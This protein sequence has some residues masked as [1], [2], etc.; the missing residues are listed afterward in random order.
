MSFLRAARAALAGQSFIRRI[1]TATVI[2]LVTLLVLLS[3]SCGG[4]TN[5]VAPN[6]NAFVTLPS[7]GSVLLLHMNGG[8]GSITLGSKT[9]PTVGFTPTGMALLPSRKFLYV[10][11]SQGYS[12]SVFSVASDYSLSLTAVPTPAG[13]GANQAVIDPTGQYLL[14]TNN[15]SNNI[16]V[17]SINS[18]TGALTEVQGSPFFANANP[19]AIVFAGNFV[20]VV[21]PGIGMVTG[22]SFNSGNGTLT[23]VPGSP[24]YSGKGAAALAVSNGGQ[25]LYVA[26]PSANNPPPYTA[27]IGNISGFNI[28]QTTGALTSITGSPFTAPVGTGPSAITIF[29]GIVYATTPGSSYSVWCFS[30][31]GQNGQL[32][33][34]ANSPFSVAGGGLFAVIDPSGKFFYIGNQAGSNIAGYTFNSSTGALSVVDNSPFA[35]GSAPG[36]M[37]FI[38]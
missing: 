34:V 10:I 16:S 35:I 38:Q 6:H 26:N 1:L 5:L 20:Y 32:V 22:F 2:V 19:T 14:V 13:S 33:P 15:F 30:I 28:D 23:Q 11:N 3:L 7:N 17:F 25:F 37:V 21:N 27:T 31:T 9:S 4:N 29:D 36:N 8:T 24:I 18:N 12:I